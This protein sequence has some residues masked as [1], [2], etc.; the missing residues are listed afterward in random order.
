MLFRSYAAFAGAG[1]GGSGASIPPADLAQL[2]K[3]QVEIGFWLTIAM[4]AAAVLLDL[5][6]LK[7]PSPA[8]AA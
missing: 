7:R 3:V 4:L 5:L 2:V 1:A 6:A 8:A